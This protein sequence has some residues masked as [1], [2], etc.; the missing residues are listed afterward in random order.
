MSVYMYVSL[1]LQPITIVSVMQLVVEAVVVVAYPISHDQ[2]N[3][4]MS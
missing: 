2:C 4:V 1:V 3:V